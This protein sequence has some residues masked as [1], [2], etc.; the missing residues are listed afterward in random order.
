MNHMC[1][2]GS[3][4]PTHSQLLIVR[5]A[6]SD[7]TPNEWIYGHLYRNVHMHSNTR[8]EGDTEMWTGFLHAFVKSRVII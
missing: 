2:N 4:S 5:T 1:V 7:I 6:A 3:T 8:P